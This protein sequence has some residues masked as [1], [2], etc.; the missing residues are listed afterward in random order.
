M[1]FGF[2]GENKALEFEIGLESAYDSYFG[3]SYTN[4]TITSLNNE[5]IRIYDVIPNRG[6]CSVGNF[7]RYSAN[8][9]TFHKYI[10]EH[11][12]DIKYLSNQFRSCFIV[13]LKNGKEKDICFDVDGYDRV[14]LRIYNNEVKREYD[15]LPKKYKKL[16][17]DSSPKLK[18]GNT[19]KVPL[20]CSKL[21]ELKIVTNKGWVVLGRDELKV[22]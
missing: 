17:V 4:L 3:T 14:I 10:E 22:F 16:F 13:S 21:L 1:V 5:E 7:E 12:S 20:H 19:F 18:Y 6:N 15:V 2:C 11:K 8:Q 9:K